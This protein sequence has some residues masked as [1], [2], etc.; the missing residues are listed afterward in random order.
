[1]DTLRSVVYHKYISVVVDA[2]ANQ[3]AAFFSLDNETVVVEVVGALAVLAFYPIAV[4][5]PVER[6]LI[7]SIFADAVGALMVKGIKNTVTQ[8]AIPN[9]ESVVG[10]EYITSACLFCSGDGCFF[11][12]FVVVKRD[13]DVAY[14]SVLQ[15]C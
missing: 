8:T 3:L 15:R 6:I 12:V 4:V 7:K 2:I 10:A 13:V 5:G 14:S 11:V 9:D 1:M